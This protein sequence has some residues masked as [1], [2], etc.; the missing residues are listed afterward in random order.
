MLKV[1]ADSAS[2]FQEGQLNQLNA[3]LMS[4]QSVNSTK[5]LP[6]EGVAPIRNFQNDI[7]PMPEITDDC[8]NLKNNNIC[9]DTDSAL[10]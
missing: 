10:I 3:E 6:C 4:K 2:A 1:G 9:E 8:L 5:D 7:A